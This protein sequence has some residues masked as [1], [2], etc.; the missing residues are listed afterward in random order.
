M[1]EVQ[2]NVICENVTKIYDLNRSRRQ[3]YSL[4][5]LLENHINLNLIM[6]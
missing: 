5:S 6:H 1:P 2:Y 3:N 4:Y